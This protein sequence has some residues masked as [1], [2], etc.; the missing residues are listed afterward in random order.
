MVVRRAALKNPGAWLYADTDCVVFSEDVTA[1]LD[2][3]PKRYGAWKVE[4]SGTQYRIIAK[5]VYQNWETGKINAKGLNTSKLTN[6][7]FDLWMQ[8]EAPVQQQ[9]QRNNFVRVMSGREM[10]YAQQRSG[11]RVNSQNQS[12]LDLL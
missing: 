12:T 5:K 2:I 8:G 4:E 11:T 7:H 3:D 6:E 10:F 1:D 9:I